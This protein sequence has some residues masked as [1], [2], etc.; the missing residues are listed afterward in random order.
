ML[1]L[2]RRNGEDV[3]IPQHD[4]VITVIEA[5]GGK[6]RLGITA[7]ANVTILRR[8]LHESGAPGRANGLA[9]KEL[10]PNKCPA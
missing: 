7:P 9:S 6:A 4:I 3:L 1:V 5:R 10:R 8:E 2:S